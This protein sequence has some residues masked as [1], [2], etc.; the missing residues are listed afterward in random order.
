MAPDSNA[1]D[2]QTERIKRRNILTLIHGQSLLQT[3]NSRQRKSD[4]QN[5]IKNIQCSLLSPDLIGR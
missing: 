1:P 4:E 3:I 5:R 2:P